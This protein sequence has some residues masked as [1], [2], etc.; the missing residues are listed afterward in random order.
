VVGAKECLLGRTG[1]FQQVD[2][3]GDHEGYDDVEEEK[4]H[5]K[6]MVIYQHMASSLR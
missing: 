6:G 5:G 2:T 4:E 1:A 3:E